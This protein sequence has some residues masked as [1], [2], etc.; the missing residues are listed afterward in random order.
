MSEINWWLETYKLLP[1]TFIGVSVSVVAFL[2]WRTAHTKVMV[3]L[4][5]KRLGVYEKA[6]DAIA[7]TN[8]FQ[9][10]EGPT[11]DAIR[12][13]YRLRSDTFF[14]FGE[15]VAENISQI[16]DSLHTESRSQRELDKR[17][18]S[19]ADRKKFAKALEQAQ[20]NKDRLER[21][22]REACI[23][24]L[25]INLKNG[26]YRHFFKRSCLTIIVSILLLLIF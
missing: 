2:Q 1:A 6:L 7:V 9:A 25:R 12:D 23:P 20:N 15:E 22:F 24:Y 11:L 4:F 13:L 18:L 16:L 14:L 19:V 17:N 5:D 26:R 3:D 10:S 8:K 21:Q